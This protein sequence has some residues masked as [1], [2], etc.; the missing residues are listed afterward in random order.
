MCG[1][2][3]VLPPADTC[4]HQLRRNRRNLIVFRW[5]LRFKKGF[6]AMVWKRTIATIVGVI[7]ALVS[8]VAFI[9]PVGGLASG[10]AIL[11]HVIMCSIGL[12]GAGMGVRFLRFAW[13]GQYR[14]SSGWMRPLVLGMGCFFPGFMFSLPITMVW[15]GYR[16]APGD[17][18]KISFYVGFLATI[19]CWIVLLRKRKAQPLS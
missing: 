5:E 10:A 19:I 12:V 15:A 7:A 3:K 14:E 4:I 6:P 2:D 1:D 13:S 17:G 9:C 11:A 8:I 16:R 18:V